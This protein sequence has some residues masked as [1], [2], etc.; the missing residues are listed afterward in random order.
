MK[1]FVIISGKGGT[2]KTSLAASLAYLAGKEAIVADCDVDAAN[3]HLLLGANHEDGQDFYSGKLASIDSDKCISCGICQENCHFRAIDAHKDIFKVNPLRCEGC[4]LC[5]RLCPEQAIKEEDMLSGKY[6]ISEVKTGTRMV[7]ARL[8]IGA[9]NSGKLVA[10]VKNLAREE[11]ERSGK[12]LIIIDGSPGIGCPVI[13]SLSGAYRAILVTEPSLS[14]FSDLK[15]IVQLTNNF[16][17]PALAVLNKADLN[18]KLAQRIKAFLLEK[19]TPLIG[20]IPYSESFSQAMIQG[21]TIL[22]IE[23]GGIADKI[24]DVWNEILKTLN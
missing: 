5:A 21:K 9:S 17:I 24:R 23:Q 7:H 10:R 14:A 1:E 18:L 20:E 13:S 12:E 3:M 16:N 11:A 4:G 8:S 15:R 2:G 22:E 19:E 6:Y